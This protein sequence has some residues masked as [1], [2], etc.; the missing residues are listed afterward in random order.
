MR[1]VIE[2]EKAADV[3][4]RGD[5]RRPSA[6]H[7]T[8]WIPLGDDAAKSLFAFVNGYDRPSLSSAP[9]PGYGRRHHRQWLKL[10]RR[11]RGF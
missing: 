10:I 4:L 7:A 8:S 3:Y 11:K 1:A 6:Q 2:A 5:H 9:I